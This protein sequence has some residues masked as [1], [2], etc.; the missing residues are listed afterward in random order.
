MHWAM[1]AQKDQK[2]VNLASL[3]MLLIADGA[4]PCTYLYCVITAVKVLLPF[5]LLKYASKMAGYVIIIIHIFT[6][7][8]L[9]HFCSVFNV[10]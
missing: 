4:N 3:R 9:S 7:F 10:C 2:D 5:L 1:L 8:N 6:V